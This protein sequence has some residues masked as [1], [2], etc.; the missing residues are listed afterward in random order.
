M[1][2]NYLID[3]RYNGLKPMIYGR[4]TM[5]ILIAVLTII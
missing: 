3:F 4:N 5:N 2:D 1:P